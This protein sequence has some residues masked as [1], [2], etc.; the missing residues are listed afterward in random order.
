M[1]NSTASERQSNQSSIRLLQILECLADSRVSLRLQEIA[2]L[3][4]M[5]QPTVLRYLYAL[6]DAHYVY[7]EENTSRYALTWR[8]CRLGTNLNSFLSL[9]NIAA[10]FVNDL[11]NSLSRGACLVIEQ[12]TECVY[13]DCIDNPHAA[14]LQRIG[15]QAP[16]HATGSGKVLLSRYNETQ[17]N[18]FISSQGLQKFT[19]YTITDADTLRKELDNIR[20]QGYGMDNEECELGLRCISMPLRDYSGAII[21]SLSVFGNTSDM[22]DE[23][24]QSMVYPA[25]KK[26]TATICYRLGY[27][28]PSQK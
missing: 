4:G 8:A 16:L 14:T 9:R 27:I 10:P 13:L 26:A 25:L 24:I 2:K 28:A 17:L 21:A 18:E 6:Q 3:V 15:R 20:L 19:Q 22:S 11:A 5:T 12:D 23:Y 7:Q 1:S